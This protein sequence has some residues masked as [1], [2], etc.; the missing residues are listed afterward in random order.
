MGKSSKSLYVASDIC[1]DIL[2][3]Q[4]DYKLPVSNGRSFILVVILHDDVCHFNSIQNLRVL[5][6]IE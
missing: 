1:I 2:F 3:V 4:V 6:Y 5:L